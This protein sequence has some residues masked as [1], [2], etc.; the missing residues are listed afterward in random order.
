MNNRLTICSLV[1][2][3][4]SVFTLLYA[5]YPE[6]YLFATDPM[7]SPIE[8]LLTA[9][10]HLSDDIMISL[11]TGYIL[12]ETGIPAFNRNDIAQPSTSYLIPYIYGT[13]LKVMSNS[14]A[15]IAFSVLG[16]LSVLIVFITLI[17]TSKS[18]SNGLILVAALCLT[19]THS[20]Y[21]L[22]GWDHLF[23]SA[24]LSVGTALV[25]KSKNS[26]FAYLVAAT[27]LAIG[28][29]ARPDGIIISSFIILSAYLLNLSRFRVSLSLVLP[30]IVL[31][32]LGLFINFL[33]FSEFTPTTARLKIGASP[34]I[35][36]STTYL[37]KNGVFS[38]SSISMI[39]ILL[40]LYVSQRHLWSN[41]ALIPIF[42]GCSLVS[43]FAAFNS[44]VFEGGRMFW[45]S[46]C[47]MAVA[48]TGSAP[49]L[50]NLNLENLNKIIAFSREYKKIS[51]FS[52][53][54]AKFYALT[55]ILIIALSSIF[56]ISEKINNLLVRENSYS[57]SSTAQIY[58]IVKWIK[59]F[60]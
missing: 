58:R 44:D 54:T 45:T 34:S 8:R 17:I 30:F 5:H 47:V 42:L 20:L 12:N 39:V 10:I 6:I 29:F 13:L 49:K 2:F 56:S 24:F 28:T 16:F 38:F 55:F 41:R 53:L 19:T 22:N 14:I 48:L 37:L 11:R 46:A 32:A 43:L 21:V 15:T 31:I 18:L 51:F 36:Y 4:T 57:P 1:I 60:K 9:P 25:L 26:V 59:K 33:Q 40:I 23:Q 50:V 7:Q 35:I 27:C 3:V 52:R